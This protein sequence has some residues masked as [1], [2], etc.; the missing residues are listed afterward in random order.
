MLGLW[1][2][3]IGK[4]FLEPNKICRHQQKFS[5]LRPQS[6]ACS[7]LNI[8]C[9]FKLW[10]SSVSLCILFVCT[11]M[12]A[13]IWLPANFSFKRFWTRCLQTNVCSH[14]FAA[15][16]CTKIWLQPYVFSPRL[17][18]RYPQM[19]ACS[20]MFAARYFQPDVYNQY[21]CSQMFAARCLQLDVFSQLFEAKYLQPTSHVFVTT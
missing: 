4:Y 13:N 16:F 19:N 14:L 5:V 20:Q 17:S 9:G 6:L 7:Y 2:W 15:S 21:V 8:L 12:F 18:S 10:R 3:F 1:R 11:H